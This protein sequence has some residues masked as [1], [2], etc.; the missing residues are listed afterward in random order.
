M[1]ILFFEFIFR[2]ANA[3]NRRI[4]VIKVRSLSE[5]REN[6]RNYKV[7][8]SN[9]SVVELILS[10]IDFK[11]CEYSLPETYELREFKESDFIN[12]HL[13]M[14]KVNMGYCPLSYWKDYILPGGFWVVEH[15]ESKKIVG[16]EFV[17]IDPHQGNGDVGS[18]EWLASDPKHRGLRIGP[19]IASRVAKKLIEDNFSKLRLGAHKHNEVVI[20][21][22]ERQGWKINKNY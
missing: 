20:R 11:E 21:M 3:I 18:L 4:S 13:L 15:L 2:L 9:S 6:Y 16:A 12:F 19:I 14:L 22:Y 10:P 5:F 7:E 17:A 1:R 8:A